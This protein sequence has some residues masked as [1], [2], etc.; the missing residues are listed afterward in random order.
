MQFN[1]YS[2]HIINQNDWAVVFSVVD[3]V[4][5]SNIRNNWNIW[6]VIRLNQKRLSVARVQRMG[7]NLVSLFRYRIHLNHS[8]LTHYIKYWFVPSASLNQLA[9]FR[10]G[11]TW[12]NTTKCHWLNGNQT[13]V[14]QFSKEQA[15]VNLQ[16]MS[17]IPWTKLLLLCGKSVK[18]K[19]MSMR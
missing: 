16:F 13:R 2:T 6:H 3:V 15:N 12:M 4:C 7:W 11:W 8:I 10:L 17:E 18:A 9:T 1:Q 19:T 5:V 14:Q